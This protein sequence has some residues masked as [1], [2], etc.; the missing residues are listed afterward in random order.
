MGQRRAEA[1]Q[2]E[3]GKLEARLVAEEEEAG[4]E[5]PEQG[6]LRQKKVVALIKS[7]RKAA[8]K[9]KM[10]EVWRERSSL[11]LRMAAG[12]WLLAAGCWLRRCS[13]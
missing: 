11:V 13:L 9:A 2:E 8:K 6:Q 12:C 1:G 5:S 7:L 4:T 10:F 3:G